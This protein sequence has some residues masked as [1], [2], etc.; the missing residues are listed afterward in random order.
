MGY[1]SRSYKRVNPTYVMLGLNEWPNLTPVI[2]ET[3]KR[4]SVWRW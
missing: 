3:C 2:F 4:E 1:V